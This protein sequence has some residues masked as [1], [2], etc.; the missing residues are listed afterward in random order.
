MDLLNAI[1]NKKRLGYIS[2]NT[3]KN[4]SVAIRQFL[5]YFEERNIEL[6]E[7]TKVNIVDF[8]NS[9]YLNLKAN[10]INNKLSALKYMFDIAIE[11]DYIDNNLITKELYLKKNKTSIRIVSNDEV[12]KI[13]QSLES[14]EL[15]IKIGFLILIEA[16]LRISELVK[17]KAKDV[18]FSEKNVYLNIMKSKRNKSRIVPVFD[19]NL[20]YMIKD[21]IEKDI[22]RDDE[23]LIKVGIRAFQ[24]HLKKIVEETGC[25]GIS[26]HSFRHFFAKE[27]FKKQVPLYQIRDILGHENIATTDIYLNTTELEIKS[28]GVKIC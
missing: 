3:F 26:A 9:E 11:S 10:T 4:Y 13:K 20:A 25:I 17:L 6:T 27:L 8:I 5:R 28:L 19:I 24:Y 15:Y 12:R 7:V 14:K 18:V 21:Y 1:E 16:G 23:Y 22:I 2:G